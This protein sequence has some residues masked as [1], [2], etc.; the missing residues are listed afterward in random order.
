MDIRLS[1]SKSFDSANFS[2]ELLFR[3]WLVEFNV[4]IGS[5]RDVSVGVEFNWSLY[6]NSSLSFLLFVVS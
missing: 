5:D 3:N 4:F 1:R 6:E 2:L